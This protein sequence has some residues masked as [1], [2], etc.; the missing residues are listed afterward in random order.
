MYKKDKPMA[1]RSSTSALCN[2]LS[3][4]MSNEKGMI[5]YSSVHKSVVNMV[6]TSADGTSVNHRQV[7][8]KEPSAT[9]CSPMI[10]Q[11]K[12]ID[13]PS[14]SLLVI[15]SQRG[16]QIFEADGT[17]MLFWYAI[18]T[19]ATAEATYARGICNVGDNILCVG[20]YQG[21]ILVFNL[22]F[23]GTNITLMETIKA[24]K[25]GI[26]DLASEGN[27]L[28]SSD[29]LG[30]I[31]IWEYSGDSNEFEEVGRI[32]GSG[33]PCN[34]LDIWQDSIL[35]GY[36]SGHLRV[37]SASTGIMGAEA[38]AH[39]RLVTSVHIAKNCGL[40]LST[41]EDSFVRVWQLSA[42]KVPQISHKFHECVPDMQLQ[43]GRFVSPDGGAFCVTGYDSN[44]LIFFACP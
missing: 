43:G 21:K 20:T 44:E 27:K 25:A 28:V 3:V 33:S 42:G 39:A 6:S 37:F 4:F 19:N 8:C 5:H 22:P 17:V 12:L 34:S 40:A 26:T 41:S 29:D 38:S 13:L 1:L 9:H 10:L 2:N 14:R 18:D 35:A 32:S 31:N 15:C 11:A 30:N 24:H 16:I 7:L 36:G 23:R